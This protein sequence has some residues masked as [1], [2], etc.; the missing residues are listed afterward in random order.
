MSNLLTYA[1]TPGPASPYPDHVPGFNRGWHELDP[2]SR[3][4]LIAV[5]LILIYAVYKMIRG[6]GNPDA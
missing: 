5:G 3:V 1:P 2:T 6:W 4:F